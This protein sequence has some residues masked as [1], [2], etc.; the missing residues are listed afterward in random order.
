MWGDTDELR[1][2]MKRN[3]EEH[4][5]GLLRKCIKISFKE[6]IKEFWQPY[7]LL[8]YFM[9]I[10]ILL[11]ELEVEGKIVMNEEENICMTQLSSFDLCGFKEVSIW[12]F[13]QKETE[14]EEKK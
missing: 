6:L 3:L 11:K 1:N 4:L 10:K 13:E 5:E 9:R 14:I 7:Y 8:T 12:D 2:F